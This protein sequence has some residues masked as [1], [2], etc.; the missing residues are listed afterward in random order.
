MPAICQIFLLLFDQEV[1]AVERNSPVIADNTPSSVGIR[2][3]CDDM[4]VSCSSHF[5][6]VGIEHRLIFCLVILVK[7]FIVLRI[8]FLPVSPCCLNRHFDAAVWHERALQRLVCLKTDDLLIVLQFRI[9][10]A[11]AVSGEACDHFCLALEDTAAG[12]LLFLQ[13]LQF[14][15][16]L[17]GPFRRA[18]KETLIAGID[19]I[20]ILNEVS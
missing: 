2:K 20:V 15:P 18:G 12:P 3:A 11:R 8:Y 9:N 7:Y 13:F 5:R 19:G 6:C 10:V 17:I 4:S 1:D 14:S 16:Q